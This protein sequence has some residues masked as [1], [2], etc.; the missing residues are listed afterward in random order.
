MPKQGPAPHASVA[1]RARPAR[2]ATRLP[3]PHEDWVHSTRNE[4][5]EWHDSMQR[6][7]ALSNSAFVVPRA[8]KT[9]YRKLRKAKAAAR[10]CTRA[11]R[12]ARTPAPSQSV[13]PSD[14][15]S[16]GWRCRIPSPL[17]LSPGGRSPGSAAEARRVRVRVSAA[18]AWMRWGGCTR[19][20][21]RRVGRCQFALET[22]SE[23]PL[24]P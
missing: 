3:T 18:A 23:H 5:A 11:P 20:V 1:L 24:D 10:A 22:K 2:R 8:M 7:G 13:L 15:A 12:A 21:C 4:R 9:N 14:A 17:R 16:R 19:A 6:L